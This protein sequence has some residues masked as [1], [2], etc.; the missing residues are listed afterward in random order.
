[1]I[2]IASFL[3]LL[4]TC[5]SLF[6]TGTD[7]KQ[8]YVKH[9]SLSHIR[10]AKNLREWFTN[11]ETHGLLRL[12]T[13]QTRHL[14][15]RIHHAALAVGGRLM[16][17]TASWKGFQLGIGGV[18]SSNIVSTNLTERYAESYLKPKWE[19]QLFDITDPASKSQ[20][21]ELEELFVKYNYKTAYIKIGKMPINT[22]L[23]NPQDS[24]MKPS[25]FSGIKFN[26]YHEKDLA[27]DA[28]YLIKTAPRSTKE[29][30]TIA[31]SINLYKRAM[32]NDSAG[33]HIPESEI[34]S[35][36]L[37]ILAAH[38][39]P[40]ENLRFRLWQYYTTNISYVSFFQSEYDY[41]SMRFGLQYLYQKQ[42]GTGGNADTD[43]KYIPDGHQV[44][45][46]SAKIAYTKKQWEISYNTTANL[47]NSRL[48]FPREWGNEPFYTFIPRY[49]IENVKGAIS[50]AIKLNKKIKTRHSDLKI[51]LAYVLSSYK[52]ERAEH[53][54]FDDYYGQFHFEIN[55]AF[56]GYF[57]GLSLR[58]LTMYYMHSEEINENVSDPTFKK[59]LFHSQLILDYRF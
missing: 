8:E 29:W 23:V 41:K 36:G 10:E 43:K 31:E 51:D 55:T 24:R 7:A 6:A 16:F 37:L 4:F 15:D 44:H 32:A 46:L 30:Y 21:N 52:L 56:H 38:Y 26:W 20:L 22:P 47:N 17:H 11:G 28:S 40:Y 48:I 54:Y 45:L 53:P 19:R 25:A 39:L 14:E 9:D 50:Q 58:F 12:N 3:A 34:H 42:S 33:Q 59:N 35:S 2:R 27:F 49:R 5:T 13:I 57:E 1:M 18:F